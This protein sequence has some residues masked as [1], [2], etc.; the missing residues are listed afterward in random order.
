MFKEKKEKN[1]C[2]LT[3]LLTKLHFWVVC[4]GSITLT[5]QLILVEAEAK[6]SPPEDTDFHLLVY[7]S[8]SM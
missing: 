5:K 2:C 6:F 4:A 7:I 8:E 3:I 1:L